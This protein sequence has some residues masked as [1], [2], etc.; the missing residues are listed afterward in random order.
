MITSCGFHATLQAELAARIAVPIATSALLQLPIVA[1]TF[2]GGSR[3]G[4]VTYEAA[5]ITTRN[6]PAVGAA[7]DTPIVGLPSQA[8]Y[9]AS[10]SVTRFTTEL[11]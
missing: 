1:R 10:S 4:I 8:R 7:P 9:A 5:S 11:R 3:P 6:L 2:S